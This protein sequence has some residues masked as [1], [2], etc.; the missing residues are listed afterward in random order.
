MKI[1]IL[2]ALLLPSAVR[3]ADVPFHMNGLDTPQ[4]VAGINENFRSLMIDLTKLRTDLDAAT[5]GTSSSG[6]GLTST[7]TWTGGN[8]FNGPAYLSSATF[9]NNIFKSSETAVLGIVS[10]AIGTGGNKCA[11]GSTITFVNCGGTRIQLVANCT[12]SQDSSPNYWANGNVIWNGTF[13]PNLPRGIYL[14][15]VGASAGANVMLP[16]FFNVEV[17]SPGI[18]GTNT[19]CL[20]AGTPNLNGNVTMPVNSTDYCRLRM[21]CLP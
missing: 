18:I 19:A 15:P 8:N 11:T 14:N 6:P 1:L 3:A 4:D 5:S 12:A 21:T 9:G 2:V 13:H 20:T 16:I 7:N 10:T 17:S